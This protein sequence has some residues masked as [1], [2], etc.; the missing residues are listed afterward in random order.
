MNR[1]VFDRSLLLAIALGWAVLVLACPHASADN[2]QEINQDCAEVGCFFNDAPGFPVT[3]TAPGHYRLTSDLHVDETYQGS[4]VILANPS[5]GDVHIDLNGFQIRGPFTC[6]GTP[7]AGCTNG[8]NTT[9]G[10]LLL[11]KGG[12]LRNGSVRGFGGAGVSGGLGHGFVVDNVAFV[13]NAGGGMHPNSGTTRAYEIRNSRFFRNGAHGFND[14]NGGNGH[15]RFRHNFFYGNQG[16]GLRSQN[17]PSITDNVFRL[18]G[19]LALTGS[20]SGCMMTGNLLFENNSNGIQFNQ[21]AG[22]IGNYCHN[23]P[24]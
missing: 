6:I 12:S 22:Q 20:G 3:I 8:P 16:E 1:T 23:G 10:L 13:E 17:G 14:A 11:V 15:G 9:R 18:N 4:A 19:S 7:V 21:C 24:C 2:S 5:S